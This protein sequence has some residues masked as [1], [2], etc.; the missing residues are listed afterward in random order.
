MEKKLTK[1]DLF[2]TESVSI[3]CF[4]IFPKSR[5]QI[6]LLILESEN[7]AISYLL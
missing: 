5:V 3:F 2:E 6:D 1:N 7:S 4:R